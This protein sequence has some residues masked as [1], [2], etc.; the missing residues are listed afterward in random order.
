[1]KST[2]VVFVVEMDVRRQS[3][4]S[5]ENCV[6]ALLYSV[7]SVECGIVAITHNI[8]ITHALLMRG[9]IVQKLNVFSRHWYVMADIA[10]EFTGQSITSQVCGRPCILSVFILLPLCL[11]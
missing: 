9:F 8:N 11:L 1:M 5:K 4:S 10:I 2:F 6:W 3:G 7:V